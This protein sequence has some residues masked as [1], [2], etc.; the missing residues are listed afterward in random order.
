MTNDE[1]LANTHYTNACSKHVDIIHTI[2]YIFL[3]FHLNSFHVGDYEYLMEEYLVDEYRAKKSLCPIC[4]EVVHNPYQVPCCGSNYCYDCIMNLKSEGTKCSQ[5]SKESES[6]ICCATC[7]KELCENCMEKDLA[8]QNELKEYEVKCR[9]YDK[10]CKWEGLQQYSDEHEQEECRHVQNPKPTEERRDVVPVKRILHNFSGIKKDQMLEVPFYTHDSG[11]K[12]H[13]W[14]F[15]N[16]YGKKEKGKYM[17]VFTCLV[18]GENDDKLEWPLRGSITVQL[19]DQSGKGNHLER[20]FHYCNTKPYDN[21]YYGRVTHSGRSEGVWP[22]QPFL[23]CEAL[24][25]RSC[26]YLRNDCLKFRISECKVQTSWRKKLGI[27]GFVVVIFIF[28]YFSY[29]TN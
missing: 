14:V 11:Y 12:M 26:D 16:G 6:L 4:L 27:V 25:G 2:V 15:P 29:F 23:S 9:Y 21:T 7:R 22:D 24:F 3:S 1:H 17:S 10:G 20:T 13:L 28:I 8:L 18:K 19:L 5:C